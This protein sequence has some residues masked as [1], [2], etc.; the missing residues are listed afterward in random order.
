MEKRT[1]TVNRVLEK[2]TLG[3]CQNLV[4]EWWMVLIK[5]VFKIVVARGKQDYT[6]PLF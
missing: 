4:Q 5:T 3:G 1:S 6:P 2:R